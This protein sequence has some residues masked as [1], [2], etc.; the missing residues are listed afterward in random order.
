MA[1][2]L[3]IRTL[4]AKD[5]RYDTAGDWREHHIFIRDEGNAKYEHLVAIH[6]YVEK[7]YCDYHDI[8][9][10][11]VTAFDIAYEETRSLGVAPCGCVHEDEPGDDKHAPYY[12]G[13]QLATVVEKLVAL[14]IGVNWIAYNNGEPE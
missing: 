1:I 8:K 14:E 4:C 13:H 12:K 5:M 3:V 6:E 11:D 10:V 2:N 7:I 9:E